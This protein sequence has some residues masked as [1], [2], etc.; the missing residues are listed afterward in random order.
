METVRRWMSSPVIVASE[1][2]VLPEA[3]RL[4]QSRRIRRLPVVNE[5]GRLVG[6]VSEGDINSISASHV[7]DVQDYNLHYRVCDLPIG[8]I[9]QRDIVT[10]TPETP[11]HAVAQL[12]LEHKIG[13]VPVVVE[14]NVIGIITESDLFRR[15]I[16]HEALE[17]AA[18]GDPA[19]ILLERV[20]R[21]SRERVRL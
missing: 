1:L 21:G 5:D 16:T 13:G 4:M 9:M 14:G 8:E 11:I 15:I 18:L 12:M 7:T 10:V 3:R 6:I 2:M 20:P 19:H 17:R